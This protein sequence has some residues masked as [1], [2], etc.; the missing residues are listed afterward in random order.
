MDRELGVDLVQALLD[1]V[2]HVADLL[3]LIVVREGFSQPLEVAQ[4]LLQ[5]L[6]PSLVVSVHS[7]F[8]TRWNFFGKLE[9]FFPEVHKK[10][11]W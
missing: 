5:E 3:R 9:N 2:L 6:L 10:T 8:I 11:I 7:V 1:Q 4:L